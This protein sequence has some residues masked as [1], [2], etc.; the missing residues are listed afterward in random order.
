MT[1]WYELIGQTPVLIEGGILECA[2][3][4]EEM[5][6][7]VASTKLFGC[8]LVSTIFLSLDHSWSGGRPIL[9]ETMAFWH[10]E[11]GY[12]QERCSTWME[13]Q[14]QH[15]RMCR[16]CVRPGAVAAYIRRTIRDWWYQAKRDAG[17]RWQ[18]LKGVELSDREKQLDVIE[19]NIFDRQEEW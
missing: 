9:F 4:F 15:A 8:C 6:R 19:A 5:D 12:E 1:D 18:E 11:G 2:R 7:R 14:E 3:R 16:E 10:G 13:A 17:R